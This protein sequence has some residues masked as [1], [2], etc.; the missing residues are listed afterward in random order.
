MHCNRTYLI[1]DFKSNLF[2]FLDSYSVLLVLQYGQTM[3]LVLLWNSDRPKEE[4]RI[5]WLLGHG[6]RPPRQFTGTE[7]TT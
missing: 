5:F 3:L 6:L 2:W 7:I 1:A 4:V